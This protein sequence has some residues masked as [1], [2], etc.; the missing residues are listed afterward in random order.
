MHFIIL[1]IIYYLGKIWSRCCFRAWLSF[2][3]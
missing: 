3:N 1:H 2:Q